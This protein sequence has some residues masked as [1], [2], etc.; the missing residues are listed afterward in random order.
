MRVRTE[1]AALT[2][3][4]DYTVPSAWV[5]D[6]RAGTR[7][8]VPLHGRTVRGW[9][10]AVDVDDDVGA[11]PDGVDVLPLKSW[12]GGGPPP[13]VV[14][15]AEWA[16]WRWAGPASFFLGTASPDAIVRALP[17]PP[18]LDAPAVATILSGGEGPPAFWRD[19]AG[20][21]GTTM[22]RLAPA[23]DQLDLVLSV[24]TDERN[25]AR[26][27]SVVVLVP[28]LGWAER[29]VTRLVRRGVPATTAWDDGAPPL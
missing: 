16:A 26:G 17:T 28:S 8:R 10:V 20:G 2:R 29:L 14:E 5:Q 12:L 7:V 25:R 19:A 21:D 3:T 18:S 1:V 24:V 4:F 9:V 27:G 6:V 22:V 11:A 15:L 13:A 23:V